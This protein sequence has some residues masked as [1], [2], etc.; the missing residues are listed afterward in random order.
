MTKKIFTYIKPALLLT[1]LLFLFFTVGAD[2]F[3]DHDD[4]CYHVKCPACNWIIH[5]VFVLVFF[6][7]LFAFLKALFYKV[8]NINTF[9]ARELCL[10]FFLPRSPPAI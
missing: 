4:C 9:F 8:L 2:L 5:T 1:A 3:H 6:L 10:A 7:P